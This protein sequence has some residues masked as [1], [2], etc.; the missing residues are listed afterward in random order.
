MKA[1]K[2]YVLSKEDIE[3][4]KQNCHLLPAMSAGKNKNLTYLSDNDILDVIGSQRH[5]S[6]VYVNGQ[7]EI[8]IVNTREA[9]GGPAYPH[10]QWIHATSKPI[11]YRART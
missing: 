3:W 9:E 5:A 4:L 7:F 1:Y 11:K 10:L 8:C 6:D 2:N